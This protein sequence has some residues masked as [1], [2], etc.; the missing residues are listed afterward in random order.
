MTE[1]SKQN[2]IF[3]CV[4]SGEPAKKLN[5]NS[6]EYI[7]VDD[8]LDLNIEKNTTIPFDFMSNNLLY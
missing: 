2:P 8:S 4:Y 5:V 7:Y 6:E 1:D 3:L